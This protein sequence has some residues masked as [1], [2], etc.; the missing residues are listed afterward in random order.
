ML[1]DIK[2]ANGF[3]LNQQ[4]LYSAK[5]AVTGSWIHENGITGEGS[6]IFGANKQ[7]DKVEIF[8]SKGE[9]RFSVLDESP[10]ELVS[11]DHQES[12]HIA[13]QYHLENMKKHLLGIAQ[14]PSTGASGLHTSWVMDRI[15]GNLK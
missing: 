14:H 4:G 7:Q 1:G 6:W 5:D 3:A 13:H 8:G 10:L 9:I 11:H 12:L 2:D 15:L